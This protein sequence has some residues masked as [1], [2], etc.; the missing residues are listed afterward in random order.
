MIPG[1]E[2]VVTPTDKGI[3][4]GHVESPGIDSCEFPTSEVEHVSC[5]KTG[6][7]KLW[8]QG[9]IPVPTCTN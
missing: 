4:F 3:K 1:D 2:K 8:Q 5:P 7:R 9:P 6:L